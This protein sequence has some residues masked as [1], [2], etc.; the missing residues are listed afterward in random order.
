MLQNLRSLHFNPNY[1]R[2]YILLLINMTKVHPDAV[3]S[4]ARNTRSGFASKSTIDIHERGDKVVVNGAKESILTILNRHS[5]DCGK[6]NLAESVVKFLKSNNIT[7]SYDIIV[8][9]FI[10]L[11][12][13]CESKIYKEIAV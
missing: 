2:V 1:P 3:P 10:Y 7:A 13:N 6:H 12:L 9:I 8:W 5:C 4:P 11:R